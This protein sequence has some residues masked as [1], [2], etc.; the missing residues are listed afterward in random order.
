LRGLARGTARF[1][2]APSALDRFPQPLH[3]NS[4]FDEQREITP[5]FRARLQKSANRAMRVVVK[6]NRPRRS[7]RERGFLSSGR[8]LIRARLKTQRS[9]KAPAS[10]RRLV[11][12]LSRPLLL[13]TA[14]AS[15]CPEC[16][17]KFLNRN[18]TA[19]IAPRADQAV[20]QKSTQPLYSTRPE[21]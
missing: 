6:K 19:R 14:S 11:S 5:A 13:G 1:A 3:L 18:S 15:R 21:E 20:S 9:P 2:S 17:R 16:S 10:V 8:G 7:I 12:S 4:M